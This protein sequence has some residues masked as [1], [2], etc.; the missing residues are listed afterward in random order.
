MAHDLGGRLARAGLVT[1]DDLA[2][3]LA[4]AP[5]HDAAF[6]RALV[7]RGVS[8][9]AIAGFFLSEGFGPLLSRTDL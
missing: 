1:R 4:T 8:E 9:D 3:I 6:V 5:P 7:R 2:E